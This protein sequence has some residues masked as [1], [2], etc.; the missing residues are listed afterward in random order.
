[1]QELPAFRMSGGCLGE[2]FYAFE[3]NSSPSDDTKGSPQWLRN[4]EVCTHAPKL[5]SVEHTLS[6]PDEYVRPGV[7]R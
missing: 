1:M 5:S 2:E 3:K 6:L 7:C 4:V